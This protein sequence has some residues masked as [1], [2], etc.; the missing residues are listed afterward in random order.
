MKITY[1]GHSA[2]EIKEKGSFKGII[3]TFIPNCHD[4][5]LINVLEDYLSASIC[6]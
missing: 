6:L 4:F 3:A 1:L 2:I 5:N